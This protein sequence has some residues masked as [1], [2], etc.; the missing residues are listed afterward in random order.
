MV[1]MV[2]TRMNNLSPLPP[3]DL[4]PQD[5]VPPD[6]DLSLF[7]EAPLSALQFQAHRA[8]IS[9]MA[10]YVRVAQGVMVPPAPS[11]QDRSDAIHH[12]GVADAAGRFDPVANHY[13]SI[14]PWVHSV[15]TWPEALQN[16]G[17]SLAGTALYGGI[18]REHFGHFITESLGR[19]WFALMHPAEKTDA[20][21][22]LRS[23]IGPPS[24]E[25]MQLLDLF[26]GLPP[27]RILDAPLRADEV[28]VPLQATASEHAI[29][30]D[31]MAARLMRRG[32]APHI[33]ARGERSLY[34]SRSRI[35]PPA[36]RAFSGS[37]LEERF[38]ESLLEAA[39]YEIFHPQEHDVADQ[40][41]TYR[42]AA[43]ILV[44]EG[45]ALH[46]VALAARRDASVAIIARRT[47][48]APL[49]ETYLDSFLGH[50]AMTRVLRCGRIVLADAYVG[51]VWLAP[52][53][54]HLQ[55]QLQRRG[56]LPLDALWPQRQAITDDIQ[57]RFGPDA[58]SR[59][60][61][62]SF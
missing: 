53:F 6:L 47:G 4:P 35:T 11:S 49:F 54:R 39:G 15:G 7:P 56:M 16:S 30:C 27:V 8:R 28:I 9:P 62:P 29:Q 32:L 12:G 3:R 5:L 37:I 43:R 38:L 24:V 20:L 59:D 61:V 58:R 34:V 44:N 14:W 22:F 2:R 45:T 21:C 55:E 36:G 18:A 57:E 52:D 46:L 50:S 40:I 19:I 31:P 42:S 60:L 51:E 23:P 17:D 26:A 41:R 48:L 13:A 10:P 33:P 25:G 1:N